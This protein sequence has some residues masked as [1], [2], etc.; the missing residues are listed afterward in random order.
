MAR[1]GA[2]LLRKLRE[3]ARQIHVQTLCLLQQSDVFKSARKERKELKLMSEEREIRLR[4]RAEKKSS[5]FKI[6]M[7]LFTPYHNQTWRI[8]FKDP[9]VIKYTANLNIRKDEG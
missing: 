8:M 9:K 4:Q 3:L 2:G 7:F 1:C 6:I 5:S